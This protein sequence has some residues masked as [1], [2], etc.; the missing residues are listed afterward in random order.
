M[1]WQF[2]SLI[3]YKWFWEEV[4][5]C[6]E[7]AVGNERPGHYTQRCMALQGRR[8]V[9][10]KGSTY[11]SILAAYEQSLGGQ[12]MQ[13]LQKLMAAAEQCGSMLQQVTWPK[14][15]ATWQKEHAMWHT[16]AEGVII[17]RQ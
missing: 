11:N 13:Q 9:G 17:E 5:G 4:Y 14:E 15:R 2:E 1:H 12:S 6:G 16:A 10:C 3:P 8:S 7:H